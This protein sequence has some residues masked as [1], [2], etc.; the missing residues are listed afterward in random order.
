MAAA[1][2]WPLF[3]SYVGFTL[4]LNGFLLVAMIWLFRT[5]WRV[6]A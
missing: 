1:G 3:M 6:A 4:L 5:R 2:N